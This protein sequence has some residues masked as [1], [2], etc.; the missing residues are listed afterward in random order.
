MSDPARF[1]GPLAQH[2]MTTQQP[3]EGYQPALMLVNHTRGHHQY[4]VYQRGKIYQFQPEQLHVTNIYAIPEGFRTYKDQATLDHMRATYPGSVDWY[5]GTVEQV[6]VAGTARRF[7]AYCMR[8]ELTQENNLLPPH[9]DAQHSYHFPE[10]L[11]ISSFLWVPPKPDDPC[12][13]MPCTCA[14]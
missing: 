4:R 5:N 9:E 10:I 8:H 14:K 7:C 2:L 6:C 1:L 12:G 13:T 11:N 3:P